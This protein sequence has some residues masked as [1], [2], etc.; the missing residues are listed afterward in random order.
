MTNIM[1]VDDDRDFGGELC[2]LLRDLGHQAKWSKNPRDIS[3]DEDH[4]EWVFVVDLAMP[5]IDGI[6]LLGLIAA[7]PRRPKVILVTGFDVAI[8]RPAVHYARSL[9]L[10]VLDAWSKP[11]DLDRV[12]R[13]FARSA[14][15]PPEESPFAEA[16]TTPAVTGLDPGTLSVFGQLICDLA[17]S[18]PAGVEAV[19][20]FVR[21]DGRAVDP[22]HMLSTLPTDDLRISLTWATANQAMH[23]FRPLSRQRDGL[24]LHLDWPDYMFSR[25][26]N[27]DRLTAEMKAHDLGPDQI[28]IGMRADSSNIEL[29]SNLG[30]FS[31]LRL[32]GFGLVISDFGSRHANLDRLLAV[33][34][35]QV[36]LHAQLVHNAA[37]SSRDRELLASFVDSLHKADLT[38]IADGVDGPAQFEAIRNLGCDLGKGRHFHAL[39]PLPGITLDPR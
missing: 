12:A 27:V 29:P 16:R 18:R 2:H 22:G 28:V 1:V 9:S 25:I 37:Q 7:F 8:L 13:V 32:G 6:K 33:P 4:T 20:Q 26:A 17:D 3:A 34:A 24:R 38:V 23:Q 10:D 21:A 11:V 30:F 19:A 31:R 15:T 39:E 36:K 14:D 35:T 5:D